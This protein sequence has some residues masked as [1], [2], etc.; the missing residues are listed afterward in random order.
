MVNAP[1]L[2]SRLADLTA[3]R[4]MEMMEFS[5]LKTLNSFLL[6]ICLRLLKFDMKIR[7]VM[8]IVLNNARCETNSEHISVSEDVKI[9]INEMLASGNH[10]CVIKTGEVCRDLFQIHKSRSQQV[11]LIVTSN[12]SLTSLNSYLVSGMLQIYRNFCDVLREG[13]TD[14]LT[15][16][17]NR[18]TFDES[19]NKVFS[20]IP[21]EED[22]Q[23]P[24]KRRKE[25]PDIYWLVMVDIDHFK[26]V[27]DK[28]GHMFGD[29]VLVILSQMM[30][31]SFRGDDM[32]FRFGGEE[33]VLILRCPD[34]AGC[35]IAL[36]RFR[37]AVENR[38]IPQVGRV[39][40]CLGACRMVRETFTAT[41]LDYADK[42]LY[43]GKHNGRNQVIFFDDLVAAGLESEQDIEAGEITLF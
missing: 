39:T 28:F 22:D 2:F 8:E 12:S 32:V 7:P 29:E 15:G 35:S 41:L 13:Q 43:H 5:L 1:L 36:E 16:L 18:K 19:I 23:Y 34:K 3:M 21:S 26:L 38:D 31:A 10:S 42:A 4:D 24:E 9:A 37:T 6:P 33:F 20:L 11:F 27:N 14:P 17:Y 30:M 25:H 40:I